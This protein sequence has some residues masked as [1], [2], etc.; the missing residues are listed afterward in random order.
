MFPGIYEFHWDLGHIIF[1]GLLFAVLSLIGLTM[2][3]AMAKTWLSIRA[4]RIPS[5]EWHEEWHSLRSEARQCRHTL[6]G[7]TEDRICDRGFACDSC[8][9]NAQMGAEQNQTTDQET[10]DNHFGY[11]MPGDKYYHRGHTTV[12]TLDDGTALIGLDDFA[13]RLIGKT[14]D[15]DL[16]AIGTQIS[17]NGNGWRIRNQ[18][19]DVRFISPIDG[20][21]LATNESAK[22]GW[23]LKVKTSQTDAQLACLLHGSEVRPWLLRELERL[24]TLLMPGAMAG[25]ADGGTPVKDLTQSYPEADWDMVWGEMFLEG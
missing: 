2:M 8:E 11:D 9:F 10:A 1:V 17:I 18:Y 21:V 24:Q 13:A 23:Y 5:I 19:G 15:V 12:Q 22:D 16:P 6:T 20:I 14:E 4:Q 7:A 25:L 3:A